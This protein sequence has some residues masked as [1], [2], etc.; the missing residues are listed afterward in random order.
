VRELCPKIVSHDIPFAIIIS[1]GLMQK[2]YAIFVMKNNLVGQT[3]MRLGCWQWERI[4]A[5]YK[6]CHRRLW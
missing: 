6:N 3:A 5:A 2:E 1:I 4:C